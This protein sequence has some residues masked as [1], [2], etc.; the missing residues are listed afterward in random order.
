MHLPP[1]G[2]ELA[3]SRILIQDTNHCVTAP[4]KSGGFKWRSEYIYIY[5]W[6]FFGPN[7]KGP[8]HFGPKK[9]G[10]N[11][12]FWQFGPNTQKGRKQ[13]GRMLFGPK[14]AE[15]SSSGPSLARARFG[16][17]ELVLAIFIEVECH[18]LLHSS[19]HK[20]RLAEVL[21]FTS[22]MVIYRFYLVNW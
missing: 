2:F 5:W 14:M 11:N 9:I 13:L 6:C 7:L 17:L 19:G 3:V 21:I 20:L 15:T 4:L 22:C 16:P 18:S 8:N 1:S 12:R 10:P